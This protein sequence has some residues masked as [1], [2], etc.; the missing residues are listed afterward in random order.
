MSLSDINIDDT[1]LAELIRRLPK[2]ELH[3]HLDGSLR[4]STLMELS[5]ARGITLPA[6]TPDA[7]ASWMRV[8]DARNLEE[9]LARFDVTL[10]VMQTVAELER[11]AYEFVVDAA[12]DGVRYIEAR[13]C[14]ALNTR[15]G[16]R[17]D[18]VMDAVLRGLSRGE[19][20][21]GTVA[22]VIVCALRSF[23]WPHAMEMAELAVAYRDRG[24]VAF[25]LAGGELGNPAHV[26]AQAFDFARNAN[27]A[28]TVHAGEGDGA[29]SIAEAVH[30]CATDR[31]GHGTRLQED[32]TLES[33][34]VDRRIPLEVCPTS[35]VQTRVAHTFAEHPLARYVALGAVVT[36]NTDN[37]LMSGV[38]LSDEFR[39]CVTQLRF[40]AGTIASLALN[41]F[42][43]SF[44]PWADRQRLRRDAVRDLDLW[45]Q[46]AS[47]VFV[48]HPTASQGVGA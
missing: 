27:L 21:S 12:L 23:P 4:S 48:A 15:E 14:P 38:S 20:E 29:T 46:N 39:H 37:R 26:H 43:A 32:A 17:V 44:L 16:L 5:A 18:E 3:C 24:V 7:L 30:R 13:F 25:D 1:T 40:D 36:I 6:A 31:I 41:A 47:S 33:Y 11:V 35:N 19:R 22:R 42:D 45:M 2:A 8:D 34:V 9:Y 28:V 10:A